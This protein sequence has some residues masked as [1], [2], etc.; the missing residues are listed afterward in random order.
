MKPN[1]SYRVS[2]YV[3]IKAENKIS[4][5]GD[6]SVRCLSGSQM[7]AGRKIPAVHAG[8]EVPIISDAGIVWCPNMISPRRR[9]GV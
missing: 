2:K 9:S 3:I 7:F 5:P 4:L 1:Q 6:S 8:I